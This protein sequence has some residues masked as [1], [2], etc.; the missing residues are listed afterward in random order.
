M[1]KIYVNKKVLIEINFVKEIKT[2]IDTIS[3]ALP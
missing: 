1:P 2:I 3:R